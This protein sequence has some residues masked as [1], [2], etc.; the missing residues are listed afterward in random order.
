M[1][2]PASMCAHWSVRNHTPRF[3]GHS[4]H[5][6]PVH[7]HD[8]K[9]WQDMHSHHLQQP[10]PVPSPAG[11]GASVQKLVLH[12]VCR[13]PPP[14]SRHKAGLV[15]AGDSHTSGHSCTWHHL[16]AGSKETPTLYTD[17]VP[18]QHRPPHSLWTI[19][20]AA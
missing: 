3:V 7:P 2:R 16:V 13:S 12:T 6:V 8:A 19:P 14:D 1:H 9:N 17:R 11:P 15:T 4:L 18:R 5:K 20:R 10:F